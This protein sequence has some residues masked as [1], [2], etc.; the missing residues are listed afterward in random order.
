MCCRYPFPSQVLDFPVALPG[1]ILSPAHV[2]LLQD[3]DVSGGGHEAC[4][5]VF[6]PSILEALRPH[7][8]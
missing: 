4:V 6:R 3:E 7:P 1:Q 2:S 5:R 8:V